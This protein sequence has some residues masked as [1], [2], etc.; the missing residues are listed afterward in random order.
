MAVNTK[1]EKE[2]YSQVHTDN[3][4]FDAQFQTYVHQPLGFDGQA[5]QRMR[6]DAVAMK[7]TTVGSVTYLAIAAPGT[8][9]SD[10]KWQCKKIDQTT[11]L[12][13]TFADGDA[14]FDNV[15]TDLTALSYQ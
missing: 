15:A 13:M 10:A 7:M 14:S 9:E 12:V 11:G 2:P 6:A 5:L 1:S 3:Q 8:V 4:S